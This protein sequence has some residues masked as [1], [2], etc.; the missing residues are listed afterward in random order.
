MPESSSLAVIVKSISFLY[1]S[2]LSAVAV[3]L[4]FAGSGAVTDTMGLTVSIIRLL[5]LMLEFT[6]VG[7]TSGSVTL[8]TLSV[9]VAESTLSNT[10]FSPTISSVGI[11][12]VLFPSELT[13]TVAI[14]S[15]SA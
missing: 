2:L 9:A 15:L 8:P 7:F 12:K 13:G 3:F 1:Q 6:S 10:L 14:F 11:T 4:S 5:L